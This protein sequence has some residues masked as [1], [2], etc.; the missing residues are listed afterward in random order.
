MLF[1][2]AADM[3]RPAVD[4][5]PQG[6][7]WKRPKE[8][9]G[10]MG[11]GLSGGVGACGGTSIEMPGSARGTVSKMDAVL[12]GYVKTSHQSPVPCP[13]PPSPHN[14]TTQ[15]SSVPRIA[16]SNKQW[17]EGVKRPMPKHIRSGSGW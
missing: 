6:D 15:Q 11:G 1:S 14:S 4:G 8:A 13:C 3:R 10:R 17:S 12:C 2:T 9:K 7:G 5:A 16:Q